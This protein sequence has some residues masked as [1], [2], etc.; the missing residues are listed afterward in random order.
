MSENISANKERN[1]NLDIL[2]VVAC[3]MVVFLHTCSK[4]YYGNPILSFNWQVSNILDSCVR[5]S[6]PLFFM[7]S[8]VL[9]LNPKRET[10][11]KNLYLKYILRLS[12]VYLAWSVIYTLYAVYAKDCPFDTKSIILSVINGPFHFWYLPVIIGLYILSPILI[13]ITKGADR[14][15]A[16]YFIAVFGISCAVKTVSVCSFLPFYDEIKAVCDIVP[17]GMV[18]QHYSYFLLG[19]FLYNFDFSEFQKRTVYILGLISPAVCA[20]LTS[21]LSR[22][23]GEA[24][25]ALYGYFSVFTLLEAAAVFTFFKNLKPVKNQTAKRVISEMSKCTLGIYL[26]HILPIKIISEKMDF[27][28]CSAL[29][30]IPIGAAAIFA[31]SFAVI[32]VLRRINFVRELM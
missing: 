30:W 32:F 15:A 10:T 29:L 5:A 13:K 2:R 24:N 12:A 27:A 20:F 21:C 1:L 31:L 11:T 14:S 6:V 16:K 9:F 19:Y 23:A 4:F 26:I 28:S 3:F 7:I 17:I 22:S 18:C 8:G 25:D